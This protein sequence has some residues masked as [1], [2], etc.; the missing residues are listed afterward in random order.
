M[1]G[2]VA[3]AR[4]DRGE[5]GFRGSGRAIVVLR[6]GTPENR[7]DRVSVG[8]IV[9]RAFARLFF[10]VFFSPVGTFFLSFLA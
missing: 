6:G 8:K 4:G 7:Y 2:D 10:I 1:R 3:T 5:R 9:Q